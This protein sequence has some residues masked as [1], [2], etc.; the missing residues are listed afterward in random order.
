M[1]FVKSISLTGWLIIVVLFLFA[2]FGIRKKLHRP[3]KLNEDIEKKRSKMASYVPPPS[4][5]HY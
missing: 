1:E 5:D 2:W 4:G 3:F